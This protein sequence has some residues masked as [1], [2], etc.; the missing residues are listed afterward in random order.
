MRPGEAVTH[1]LL[2]VR[3]RGEIDVLGRLVLA[4]HFEEGERAQRLRAVL[5]AQRAEAL[6]DR[7]VL[8][9][10]VHRNQRVV[11]MIAERRGELELLLGSRNRVLDRRARRNARRVASPAYRSRRGDRRGSPPRSARAST[12]RAIARRGS[13]RGTPRVPCLQ[14]CSDRRRRR[15]MRRVT[16]HSPGSAALLEHEGVGRI[17]PDG[18]EKLQRG[19]RVA[20]RASGR[21]ERR[22]QRAA[23]R[24]RTLPVTAHEADR[25]LVEVA[26]HALFAASSRA[27]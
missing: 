13:P 12:S 9:A 19:P 24:P 1:L 14:A 3:Q 10:A 26:A 15:R 8:E 6:A 25:R 7:A 2:R 11:R 17:E 21:C 18:A 5:R 22:H 27:R 4:L 16:A 20:D 23:A